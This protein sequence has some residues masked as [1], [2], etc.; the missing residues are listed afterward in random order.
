M[1]YLFTDFSVRDFYVGQMH[2]A[3]RQVNPDAKLIDLL[4]GVRSFDIEGA[5]RLLDRLIEFTPKGSI[6]VGVVDPGVGGLRKPL[7]S[8]VDGR[9]LIGPDNGLFSPIIRRSGSAKSFDITWRP[10]QLS[11]TFHGRDLFAPVAAMLDL[12]QKPDAVEC[13]PFLPS[14]PAESARIIYKD[15]Y[16]NLL[17]GLSGDSLDTGVALV[18]N[19][20]TVSYASRY[21]TIKEG[22]VCWIRNSIGLV[23]IAA[24]RA[25]ASFC[26][27]A[28]VGDEILLRI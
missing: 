14:W 2:G 26:L 18:L 27:G 7:M 4:H 17:T 5:A 11:A 21:E 8:R 16:G 13:E 24:N 10:K 23:E 20:H 28:S 12:G 15:H 19:G 3:I 9:W 1:I 6:I 25:D 22:D